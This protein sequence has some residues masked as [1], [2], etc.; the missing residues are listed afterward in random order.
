MIN[1][2]GFWRDVLLFILGMFVIY[3]ILKFTVFKKIKK[4]AKA[5]GIAINVMIALGIL[6][7]FL[8]V[9]LAVE[10]PG[11]GLYL[12]LNAIFGSIVQVCVLALATTGIVLIFKTSTTTNF[13]Q[14]MI[15]TVAAFSAAKIS[16]S[17]A[18]RFPEM[19]MS[20]VVLI[21][22]FSGALVSFLLGV[23]ID[24]VIIRQAKYPTPVGKQ[25][26][27]MGLVLVF[28]GLIPIVF[29]TLPLT[30]QKLSYADN[31]SF[32]IGD[33]PLRYN[34]TMHAIYSLG[35]TIV[36]L[37]VLFSLLRFTKWGLGVRA[38]ASNEM[39]ASM[40]GV[41]T[42]IIT[43]MSWAIAGLL[44]GV[45]AVI[46]APIS[47]SLQV[48]MMIPT[49]VNGF[50]AAILG[51][52]TSFA[53]PLISTILIPILTNLMSIVTSTWQNAVV[54]IIILV[55]VL[56]KPSGLFGKQVAKKV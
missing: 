4:P 25:M 45:A 9:Y 41:N 50:L 19:N 5:S 47:G 18:A 31:I 28:T 27:T 24:V 30:V 56:V 10:I 35:I 8:K 23:F 33:S 52:F 42:R 11:G 17:I 16:L 48:S 13:A 20:Y 34:I 32:T 40:M 55:I 49:Q 2:E 14:G 38:T 3:Q 44:G 36:L 15:A 21:A 12:I 29:G 43:A 7:L 1:T 37:V 54:Y 46:L 26:I 6:F 53:G 22:M 51:S 39:V